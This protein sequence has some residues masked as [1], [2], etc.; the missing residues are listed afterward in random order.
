LAQT[1]LAGTAVGDQLQALSLD[2]LRRAANEFR[3]DGRSG[4]NDPEYLKQGLA[5]MERRKNGDFDEYCKQK[6]AETWI[7]DTEFSSSDQEL[8]RE[9]DAFNGKGPDASNEDMPDAQD[10]K[11]N[12]EEEDQTFA[13]EYDPRPSQHH[14]EDDN[15]PDGPATSGTP[16]DTSGVLVRYPQTSEGN[17]TNGEGS[18]NTRGQ[19]SS[20]NQ[21]GQTNTWEAYFSN[22]ADVSAPPQYVI[23]SITSPIKFDCF[24]RKQK[25]VGLK[26]QDLIKPGDILRFE[27][28]G[29]VVK[30]MTV[31]TPSLDLDCLLKYIVFE[32]WTVSAKRTPEFDF[33]CSPG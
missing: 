21:S 13:R 18:S 14:Q 26:F 4:F 10:E 9:L 25:L 27:I 5:A 15:P 6:F 17:S 29:Q 32:S 1:T 16:Q 3:N 23:S 11:E 7:D 12:E 19:S 33:Q 2:D 30:E 22:Y 8:A 31:S 24:F 20:T 28:H